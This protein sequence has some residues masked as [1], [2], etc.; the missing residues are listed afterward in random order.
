[1][2]ALLGLEN[3]EVAMTKQHTKA[4]KEGFLPLF[5]YSAIVSISIFDI[6]EISVKHKHKGFEYKADMRHIHWSA[7]RLIAESSDIKNK[8]CT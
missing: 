4:C 5:L 3:V 8:P 1:M 6:R 2:I 7:I